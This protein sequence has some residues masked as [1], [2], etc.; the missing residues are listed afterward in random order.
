MIARGSTTET[1]SQQL[2]SSCIFPFTR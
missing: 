2:Y 1:I